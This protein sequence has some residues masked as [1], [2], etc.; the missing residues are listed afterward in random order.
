MNE[1][2]LI[3]MA[4]IIFILVLLL[5]T[6]L[7]VGWK[8]KKNNHAALEQLLDSVSLREER[9]KSSLI[10]YLTGHQKM[11][12]QVAVEL[13]EDFIEAEKQFLYQFLEQQVK[14]KPMSDFYRHLCELLDKYLALLP[15]A[16]ASSTAQATKSADKS[17]VKKKT[18][19]TDWAAAFADIGLDMSS[20]STGDGSKAKN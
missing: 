3:V 13:C 12:K 1:V 16:A 20:L 2:V 7:F 9:R 8:R 15:Q 5:L 11:E 6:I 14:Q 17:A 10:D 18:L 4:E 19:E